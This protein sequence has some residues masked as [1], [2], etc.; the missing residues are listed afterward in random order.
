MQFRVLVCGDREWDDI[1]LIRQYVVSW[2]RD[3]IL[4]HGDCR[5]ADRL[6]A[7]AGRE[8]LGEDHVLAFPAD[9]DEYGRAAGPIRNTQMLKEGKP[10]EVFAFHNHLAKSKGTLNMIFQANR[11]GIPVTILS[12]QRRANG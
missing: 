10:D 3:T 12:N 6:A 5:G 8:I 2:G 9:W 7:Q 4:I 1:A 11:K